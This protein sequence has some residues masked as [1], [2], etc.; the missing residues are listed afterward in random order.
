MEMYILEGSSDHKVSN[1]Q[2]GFVSGRGTEIA[3]AL[4]NDLISYAN[5]RERAQYIHV[6]LIQRVHLM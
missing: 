5:V 1:S 2:F 4:V 3:T 6:R